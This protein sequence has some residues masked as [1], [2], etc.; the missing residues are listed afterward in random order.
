MARRETLQT[1]FSAGM[2]DPR[3]A[4][5]DDLELYFNGA[6]EILN[7]R[8]NPQG[9]LSLRPGLAY[10][11]PLRGAVSFL[12]IDAATLTLSGGGSSGGSGSSPP[13]P[14]DDPYPYPDLDF[15]DIGSA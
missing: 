13:P 15:G 6:A 2:V 12:N 4:E 5:R 7:L 11:G 10:V 9:G 1:N 14:P 8:P 3:L